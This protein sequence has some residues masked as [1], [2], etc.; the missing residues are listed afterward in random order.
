MPEDGGTGPDPTHRSPTQVPSASGSGAASERTPVQRR[1][2]RADRVGPLGARRWR[3]RALAKVGVGDGRRRALGGG[4]VSSRRLLGAH[5]P[6]ASP[7]RR[8]TVA[9]GRCLGCRT[10][11]AIDVSGLRGR[12]ARPHGHR[13]SG[14]QRRLPFDAPRPQ[15]HAT[16]L[17]GWKPEDARRNT[18]S[19]SSGGLRPNGNERV[20]S[21]S[22]RPLHRS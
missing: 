20:S 16:G 8:E 6:A 10:Q 15:R 22:G 9:G 14:Q 17:S 3:R 18:R 7:E 13:G 1:V 12:R 2:P 21:A 4:G 19:Q 5:L 11:F